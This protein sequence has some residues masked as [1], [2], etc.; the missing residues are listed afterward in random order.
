MK[1][2]KLVTRC[3]VETLEDYIN[4]FDIKKVLGYKGKTSQNS[5]N[6]FIIDAKLGRGI[7]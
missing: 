4:N 5:N 6:T 3:M 2:L 7:K 1:L